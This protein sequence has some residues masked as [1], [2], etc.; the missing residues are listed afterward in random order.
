MPSRL[1]KINIYALD[2]RLALA[3]AFALFIAIV[4]VDYITS[5]ELSL[6]PFY[7]FIVLLVTWNCSWQLG[8]LFAVMSFAAPTI[9]GELNGSPY[10]E[11]IYLYVDNAN[12]LVSYLVAMALTAQLKAQHEREKHSA[13]RDYLTG[14]ANLKGFYEELNIELARHRREK[15]PL[16][17]AYVD[18]DNFKAVNDRSGHKEGDR[19]LE[20]VAKILKSNVRKTDVVGRLGGDEFALV[21]SKTDQAAAGNVID[22][23]RGELTARM[24]QE[25]WPVTFS[26][27]LAVFATVPTSEDEVILF[28]DRLMYRVKTSGKNNVLCESYPP[29]ASA[30]D[31]NVRR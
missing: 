29:Q 18:C 7:L 13:R 31:A 14:L 3:A 25:S 24:A 9:M 21:L 12:R 2:R 1:L 17:V 11:P 22:K 23:L 28:A 20:E 4:F 30:V 27:G 19:L 10:S 6:T 15:T 26:I 8:L 5:Y 16:S